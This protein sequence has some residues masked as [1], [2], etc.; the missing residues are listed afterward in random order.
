MSKILTESEVEQVALDIFS[1]LKY[2]IIYGPDIAPE[3]RATAGN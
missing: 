2:K 3:Y 1:E